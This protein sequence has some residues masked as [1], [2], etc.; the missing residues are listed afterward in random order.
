MVK[1]IENFIGSLSIFKTHLVLDALIVA[2]DTL[3]TETKSKKSVEHRIFL[4]ADAS[5]SSPMNC[6]GID[7]VLAQFREFSIR[8]DLISM[9]DETESIESSNKKGIYFLHTILLSP[10]I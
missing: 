3:I 8:L 2:A 4:L 7:Q 10:S 6:S 1:G 5:Q 9:T